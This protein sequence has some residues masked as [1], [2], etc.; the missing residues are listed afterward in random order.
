MLE[1][2]TKQ[3]I[4]AV[5]P[6]GEDRTSLNKVLGHSDW[7]LQFTH[8]LAETQV[9]L[10]ACPVVVVLTESRLSDG[11]SW[12]DILRELQGMPSPPPLIVADRLADETLWAEVLNL[13]AY[14]LLTKPFNAREVLHALT[15][16][17]HFSADQRDRAAV[18]RKPPG[19]TGFEQMPGRRER[20]AFTGR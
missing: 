11:Y 15:T 19:S 10:R 8:A 3:I 13:G 18:L 6:P 14:D 16:A 4:L 17:C 20:A 12:K 9:V 2:V 7:Q 5:F 1:E